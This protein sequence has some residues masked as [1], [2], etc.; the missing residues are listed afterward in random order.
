MQ[1]KD[2][3]RTL[4]VHHDASEDEIKKAYRKL[5]L[6]YHPDHHRD[7]PASAERFKEISEAYAVL[8]NREKKEEYDQFGHAA[9]KAR[10]TVEDIYREF[11]NQGPHREHVFH[12]VICW[13]R[14]RGCNGWKTASCEERFFREYDHEVPERDQVGHSFDLLLSLWEVSSEADKQI[15]LNVGPNERR[16]LIRIPP[17]VRSGTRLR[18]VFDEGGEDI[19]LTARVIGEGLAVENR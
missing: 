15:V 19:V 9:F 6:K 17:G 7:G 2:Y 11:D 10:Y 13:K 8:A 12:H 18:L 4:G 5:A 14:V 3:Y 1:R 16:F